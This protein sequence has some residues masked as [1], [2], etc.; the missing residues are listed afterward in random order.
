MLRIE[1]LTLAFTPKA[2]AVTPV[3]VRVRLLNVTVVPAATLTSE[4]APDTLP[5][6]VPLGTA[7]TR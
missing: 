2:K 3:L 4:L 7:P 5:A 6:S 1:P